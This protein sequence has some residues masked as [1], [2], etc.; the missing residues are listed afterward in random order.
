MNGLILIA[1]FLLAAGVTFATN[2]LA[3]IP[4]RR[5]RDKHWTEQA[6]ILYPVLMAAHANLLVV[7]G[8]TTLGVF[9]IWPNTSLLWLFAGIFAMLGATAGTLF[10]HHEVYPRISAPDLLRETAIGWLMRFLIWI[11]FIAAAVA[12]PDQFNSLALG[13]A[14]AVVLLWALWTR[15]G[16]IWLGK[17]VGL[18]VPA[19]ERLSKIAKETSTG[20]NVPY[21]EV[22]LVRSSFCQAYALPGIG[23]LMFTQR[24]LDLLPDEGTA[25]ICAHELA[26]LTESRLVAY[27]RSIRILAYIPWIFFTPLIHVFGLGATYGLLFFTFFVP[28]IYSKLSRKLESRAD[29]MA[30]AN[31]SD[32]GAYARA[33]ARLYE[34]NLMPVVT[35]KKQTHPHLYDRL[36]ATGITPDF[37]RP[38]PAYSMAWHGHAFAGL[39]GI[40]LAMFAIHLISTFNGSN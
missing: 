18:F 33:L 21:R 15:G 11:I 9:L 37:P 16:W 17:I 29:A 26:H 30:K 13:I 20:M 27:S 3:L 4:W 23:V 39:G 19:P 35:A 6:R 14:I 7:P 2:W 10:L 28:R 38:K 25:A 36:L 12:M 34:D 31:E 40:L 32:D 5:N 1:A 22:L 8:I 24:L